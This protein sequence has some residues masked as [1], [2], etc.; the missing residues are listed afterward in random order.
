MDGGRLRFRRATAF[1]TRLNCHERVTG[2]REG[3]RLTDPSRQIVLL[4]DDKCE[5]K[6]GDGLNVANCPH[7]GVL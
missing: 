6:F 1:V 5:R 7:F 3:S 2:T 4:D